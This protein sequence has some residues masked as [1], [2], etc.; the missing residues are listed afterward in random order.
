[1]IWVVTSC[2]LG[3]HLIIAGLFFGL[4]FDRE[5]G[6]DVFFRYVWR[7]LQKYKALK[8]RRKWCYSHFYEDLW[9]QSFAHLR[10]NRWMNFHGSWYWG[11]L[12]KTIDTAQFLLKSANMADTSYLFSFLEFTYVCIY[13]SRNCFHQNYVEKWSTYFINKDFYVNFTL[14]EIFNKRHAMSIFPN[15]Y[16]EQSKIA[17]ETH[18]KITKPLTLDYA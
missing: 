6:G 1:M 17:F 8:S 9:R 13:G 15:L 18:P 3:T 10:E 5:N 11:I 14:F 4:Y 16:I 2:T 7:L 12:L